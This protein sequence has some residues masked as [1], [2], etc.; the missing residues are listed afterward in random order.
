[1]EKTEIGNHRI[2]KTFAEKN[3]YKTLEERK[4]QNELMEVTERRKFM[5]RRYKMIK[6]IPP[7][8]VRVYLAWGKDMA[9]VKIQNWWRKL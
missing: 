2:S 1:M 9:A 5:E 8:R 3:R 6:K 4:F 7:S